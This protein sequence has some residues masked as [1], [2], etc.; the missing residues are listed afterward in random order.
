ML[1]GSEPGV[2]Y[3]GESEEEV[4]EVLGSTACMPGMN[5]RFRMLHDLWSRTVPRSRG[6]LAM[7]RSAR[8]SPA[9]SLG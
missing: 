3:D 6:A 9:P 4:V 7:S 2:E 8:H 5:A 1:S